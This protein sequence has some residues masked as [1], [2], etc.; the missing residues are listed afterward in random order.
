M[1]RRFASRVE[2]LQADFTEMA[3]QTDGMTG[4]DLRE[5][6][7]GAFTCAV[8]EADDPAA[9]TVTTRHF[10]IA[11]QRAKRHPVG[12]DRWR[13]IWRCTVN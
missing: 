12:P 4:A 6:V 7:V 3:E 5:L 2:R 9:A 13:T 11:L 8:D 1:L 10:V